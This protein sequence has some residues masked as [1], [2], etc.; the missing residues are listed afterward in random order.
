MSW[1]LASILLLG[2]A[3]IVGFAWYE[4]AQPSTQMLALVATLA[5]LAALGRV[6]F[7][8]VPNVKPTT[9][10]VLLAGYTLGGAPGFMVG[11][12]AGL[13]SNLFLGQG[14]WT[15]WQI[16]AWGLIGI[17]G[18]GLARASADLGRLPLAL[19]CGV[20]GLVFGTIM[21]VHQWLNYSG[22]HALAKLGT[23][24]ATAAPFDLAH[25][26]GNIGFCLAFGPTLVRALAR[27]NTR[28]TVVW[29]R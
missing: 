12:L 20:A 11:A 23:T 4:R 26:A 19:A 27:F 18:A 6:A 28:F 8:P 5:A 22:D 15:P 1:I 13:A 25:A 17:A 21:N 7:A 16:A 3:L 10:V 9:D 2:A 14:P 29:V 24:F